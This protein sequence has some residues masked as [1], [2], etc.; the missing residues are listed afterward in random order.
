VTPRTI[1]KIAKIAAAKRW[2]PHGKRYMTQRRSLQLSLIL[3][4]IIATVW[5]AWP[6]TGPMG[7]AY[8]FIMPSLAMIIA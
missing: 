7:D 2:A 6:R 1:T 4:F 8:F 5:A 3:V